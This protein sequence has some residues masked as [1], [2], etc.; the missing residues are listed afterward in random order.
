M[1]AL[2]IGHPKEAE[3][4][5]F[6]G[7]E[8]GP[9]SRWRIE[10]HLE[11]CPRC[12]EE[13]AEYFRLQEQLSVLAELP[14]VDWSALANR[15]E[16]GAAAPAALP[17]APNRALTW[18]LAAALGCLLAVALAWRQW[19]DPAPTPIRTEAPPTAVAD[20]REE[21]ASKAEAAEDRQAARLEPPSEAAEPEAPLQLPLRLREPSPQRL[22]SAATV[23]GLAESSETAAA[24]APEPPPEAAWPAPDRDFQVMT[25]GW[26]SYQSF[27]PQSGAVTVT[28]VYAP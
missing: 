16:R 11:R 17:A 22:R 27:D 25:N 4:A 28:E 21:P 15:I 26:V 24:S 13:A 20:G 2:F 7:G 10:R 14:E 19:V 5:L 1:S 18:R 6:A 9:L 8:L 3:L 12:A 23:E